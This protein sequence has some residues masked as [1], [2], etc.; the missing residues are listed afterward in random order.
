MRDGILSKGGLL[1]LIMIGIVSCAP[2]KQL[3]SNAIGTEKRASRAER[4]HIM[5]NVVQN[6]THFTTF[7]G[8]AKS[9]ISIN[10]DTYDV[11]ANVRIER[12]K[13]IWISV[14]ALMG[15]EAGRVLI[16]P[17]SVKVMNRLQGAYIQKPFEYIYQYTSPELGFTSLQDMLVG[18]VIAQA[19]GTDTDVSIADGGGVLRGQANDLLFLIQLAE[20]HKAKLML[21]DEADRHQRLE[22]SYTNYTP[23]T[24]RLFPNQIHIS[25]AAAGLDIRSEMN[26]NRVSYDEVLDMPFNIPA[27]YKEIQ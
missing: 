4:L 7:S 26:Y 1:W 12:D 10:K 15:V 3:V 2:K 25:I 5:S 21:L 24:G 22:A 9:K 16:T 23:Y 11:T 18:N 14:T 6:Q 8:R 27:R 17:D 19:M 20:N 13:A